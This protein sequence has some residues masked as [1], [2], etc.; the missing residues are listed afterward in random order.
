[1]DQQ[2]SLAQLI[3]GPNPLESYS[4]SNNSNNHSLLLT[5]F[6]THLIIIEF[7]K[8]THFIFGNDFCINFFSNALYVSPSITKN[9]LKIYINL[10]LIV[11][12][13]F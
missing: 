13:T 4:L 1:M 11:D 6:I 3:M 9:T 8:V 2:F 10:M 5:S 7:P 12:K